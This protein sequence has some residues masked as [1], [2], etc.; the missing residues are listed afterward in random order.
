M[1]NLYWSG[2]NTLMVSFQWLNDYDH[3]YLVWSSIFGV[4][5]ISWVLW[6]DWLFWLAELSSFRCALLSRCTIGGVSIS[7]YQPRQM[8]HRWSNF[9][10]LYRWCVR[11]TNLM[12]N[13][14][15]TM[16]GWWCELLSRW[17]MWCW[18][19]VISGKWNSGLSNMSWRLGGVDSFLAVDLNVKE[20]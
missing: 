4:A 1:C 2:N 19:H 9:L 14:Q 5:K 6:A 7:W 16:P 12:I 13:H 3:Q 20:N 18:R 11:I 8:M 10:L 17:C 15:Q